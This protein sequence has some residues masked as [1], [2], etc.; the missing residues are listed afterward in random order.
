MDEHIPVFVFTGGPCAGKTTGL[1]YVEEKLRDLGFAVFI[2]KE[3][4]TE[5]M[6]SGI[7]PSGGQFTEEEFQ[8]L[9]VRRILEAEKFYKDA[10]RFVADQ[11]KVILCDRG[12][13]DGRAYMDEAMLERVLASHE[14]SAVAARDLRY[15]AVFHLR[16]AAIG[17]EM[18]YSNATNAVRRETLAEAR[19]KDQ[20][21]LEAWLGHPHLRVIDNS[22]DFPHKM[23][24]LLTEVLAAL[25]IPV[26]LEIERKFLVAPDFDPRGIPVPF[27][28]IDIEQAYLPAP[29]G[30]AIRVRKRGQNGSAVY[31][32]THKKRLPDA[33]AYCSV[34]VE[35]HISEMEYERLFATRNPALCVIRK[36]R[37]CFVWQEQYFELDAFIEPSRELRILE[38][39]LTE[40]RGTILLPDF[41][42][43]IGEMRDLTNEKIARGSHA[44]N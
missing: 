24:R 11:K 18:F 30:E 4:A 5:L 22:T 12:I 8:G 7:A 35:R 15:D 25:D 34:E 41:I 28:E 29:D 43:V 40:A 21:T 17:A 2:V 39:E 44:L 13:M 16:S 32:H 27:Q 31:Y 3:A 33:D 19:E 37:F 36:K 20:Q 9:V 6:T 1:C 42:P 10:A 14:L 23:K 38:V 26:P